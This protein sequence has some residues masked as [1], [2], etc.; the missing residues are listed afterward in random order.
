MI[1]DEI[2]KQHKYI[3]ANILKTQGTICAENKVMIKRLTLTV[4]VSVI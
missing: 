2:I 1:D 3:T 4:N